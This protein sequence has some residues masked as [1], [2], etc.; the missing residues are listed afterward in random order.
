MINKIQ[1]HTIAFI[2]FQYIL[3]AP[4]AHA[5]GP[6][7]GEVG[8]QSWD[9]S[10]SGSLLLD[11]HE[12]DGFFDGTTGL[13]AELWL[14]DKWGLSA[15][16]YDSPFKGTLLKVEEHAQINILRRLISI[17]DNTY[18]ALGAGYENLE[19]DNSGKSISGPRLLAAGR[20]GVVGIVYVYGQA[21]WIPDLGSFEEINDIE[22]FDLEFGV[23]IDPLP[24]TSIKLGYR[25]YEFDHSQGNTNSSGFLL[26]AGIHW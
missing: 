21:A 1:K 14:G 15:R 18:L 16:Y 9:D 13:Y 5:L 11:D 22:A 7:D 20:I 19:L 25:R 6:V 4:F 12:S 3:I 17:S 23:V 26:G 10:A 8:I 24:F 2:A